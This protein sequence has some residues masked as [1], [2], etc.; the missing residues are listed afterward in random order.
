M[1]SSGGEIPEEL[2]TV[3]DIA[4][5]INPNTPDTEETVS[6]SSP[7]EPAAWPEQAKSK[8]PSKGVI[9]IIAAVVL[10]AIIIV[11]VVIH[12]K[13]KA[14]A[15][16]ADYIENLEAFHYSALCGTADAETQC[17]LYTSVW[18]DAIYKEDNPDTS[19]YTHKLNGEFADDFNDALSMVYVYTVDEQTA[20]EEN[21]TEVQ[22]LY[23]ALMDVPEDADLQACFEVVDEMYD[24]Y[25]T[26]TNL[27]LSPSG[28]LTTYSADVRQYDSEF[29]EYYDKL[30]LLIPDE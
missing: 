23:Q 8:K 2:D 12:S 24:T 15:L 28:S 16:R 5:P 17:N 13:S 10:I 29:M 27:A 14:A 3:D 22:G 4:P 25:I 9:V 21:Q 7:T 6:G 30:K 18:H 20:I 19:K 11:S 26:F 1:D